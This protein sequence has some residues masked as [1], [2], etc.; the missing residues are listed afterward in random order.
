MIYLDCAAT[1]L[2][3]PAE[4]GYAVMCAVR[5]L[6][7]PGRG[8]YSTAMAAADILLNCRTAIAEMFH[9]PSPEQ[10]VF[11]HN[12][13]HGLNIAIKSLIGEEDRVVISGYEHN[14]VL[15][16]LRAIRA[17]IDV[18]EAPLF[19]PDEMI[20]AFERKLPGAKA[21][22]C[23]HVSNVFGYILPLAE[24]ATLC[25]KYRVPLIVDAS[26]SAGSVELDF[27]A[28]GCQF[29]AMP[30]HKGLLGPQGTGVLLCKDEDVKSLLEGGT[31]SN[32]E[33][34]AM[35][36]FLPDRLEAGTHNMPG[37]AGLLAGV[38]WVSRKTPS[39][40]VQHERERMS[41]FAKSLLS[42]PGLRV[43]VA[44]DLHMQSGVL[45]VQFEG[46]DCEDAARLLGQAGIAVRAGLHCAP[47]AHR[48][49]NTISDGTVRFSFSPFNT[50]SEAKHAAAAVRMLYR[51]KTL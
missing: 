28:L 36:D 19:V 44:D 7:S 13:T 46:I 10:V 40:I 6:S 26:Q 3:K 37:I 16:P 51:H 9:V 2:Q 21:A 50:W 41:F 14:A 33:L 12:A 11:T 48:T 39:A 49:G 34:D 18:A 5:N 23:C 8:G 47:L 25:E 32:S 24:I 29:A 15:R 42:V 35:P 27:T 43:F 22:V 31:G 30:G 45:S 1:S 4:V 38:R 20:R 17:Q